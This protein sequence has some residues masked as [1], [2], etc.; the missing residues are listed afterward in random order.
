VV[1]IEPILLEKSKIGG[2]KNRRE[3]YETARLEASPR[4][5]EATWS[6]EQSFEWTPTCLFSKDS[7]TVLKK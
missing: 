5:S 4:A 7:R 6:P 2:V 1:A 3:S